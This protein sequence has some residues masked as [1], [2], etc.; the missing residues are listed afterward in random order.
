MMCKRDTTWPVRLTVVCVFL[1]ILRLREGPQATAVAT[2][3][4]L[5]ILALVWGIYGVLC[6]SGP[7]D[8]SGIVKRAKRP[9]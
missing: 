2:A 6:L 5:F 3:V 4:S 1:P 8:E 9:S 7:G